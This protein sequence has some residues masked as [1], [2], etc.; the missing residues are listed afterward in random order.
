[1]DATYNLIT[2][3]NDEKEGDLQVDETKV[4]ESYHN[5][6]DLNDECQS[7]NTNDISRDSVCATPEV[8]KVICTIATANVINGI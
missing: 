3:Y 1:M 5:N 2:A 8:F 7:G 6:Q 4:A